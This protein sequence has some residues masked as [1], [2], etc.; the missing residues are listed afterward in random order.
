MTQTHKPSGAYL[1]VC[2]CA[3]MIIFGLSGRL[4]SLNICPTL[5]SPHISSS[6]NQ[7]TR[8]ICNHHIPKGT[9]KNSKLILVDL[10]G[11]QL[12]AYVSCET[13]CII[14]H[15]SA[16]LLAGSEKVRKTHAEGHTLKEAQHINKS[17]S[18]LGKLDASSPNRG[19]RHIKYPS[20][21]FHIHLFSSL[22]F[23]L[24]IHRYLIDILST[25]YKNR[26]CY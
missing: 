20:Q 4:S 14:L 24:A 23:F 17:L 19:A 7:I 3:S 22:L 11:S 25:M 8:L 6:S 15:S 26:Q 12:C 1:V 16:P 9:K 10:A 5:S 18:A 21:T 2:V 13:R